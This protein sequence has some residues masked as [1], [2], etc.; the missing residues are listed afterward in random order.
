MGAAVALE[1]LHCWQPWHLKAAAATAVAVARAA[2][3]LLMPSEVDQKNLLQSREGR[4]MARLSAL[5]IL[6]QARTWHP[7]TLPGVAP[8]RAA[9]P[10]H[11]ASRWTQR[12]L[13]ET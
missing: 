4:Q 11:P 3:V 8:A 7:L 1:Q 5:C 2:V 10:I 6:H 9:W 12:L 13:H